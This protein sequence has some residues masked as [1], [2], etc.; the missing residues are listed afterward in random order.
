MN[1]TFPVLKL[2][3]GNPATNSARDANVVD[4]ETGGGRADGGRRDMHL[5]GRQSGRWGWSW[6][7]S[8]RR[9]H[10]SDGEQS[11]AS[12]PDRTPERWGS[13]VGLRNPTALLN[14]QTSEDA[15]LSFPLLPTLTF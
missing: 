11:S 12:Q 6:K 9:R 2:P 8:W 14:P 10:P 13:G 4:A 7:G 3:I 5:W 15:S 1:K